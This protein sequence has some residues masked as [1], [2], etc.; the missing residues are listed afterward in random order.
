MKKI[1]IKDIATLSQ[2]S[3][4]S[5]SRY[6][7]DGYVSTEAAKRIQQAIEE[8]GFETNFFAKRLKSKYS[9]L[10]GVIIPRLDSVSIGKTLNGI[11][12]VLTSKNMQPLI[13]SSDLDINKEIQ[14]IKSLANQ[15]VDGIIVQSLEITPAHLKLVKELTIPV[16][17]TGQKNE[18][19]KYIKIDD[20]QAGQLLGEYF[21]Q[22]GHKNLV[23]LGVSE[24][25]QAVGLE[26]KQGFLD[27]FKKHQANINF[28]FVETDFSF[29]KAYENGR[30]VLDYKPDAI[31]CATDNIAMGL[32]SYLHEHGVKVPTDVALAGFGGYEIGSVM[33][34]PLTTV[35]FDQEELGRKV[36]LNL[37]QDIKGESYQNNSHLSLTLLPRGSSGQ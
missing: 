14:N 1:T 33:Y 11:N 19:V 31:I 35:V 18:N 15:G 12:E 9:Q 22:L 7:N 32:M 21:Y 10:I 8:T 3:K 34:P 28:N 24:I 16:W 13:V 23:F 5:V 20:Y 6:L 29:K 25:D 36:A 2:T 30:K 4:S 26:R 17:F 27:V 37:L